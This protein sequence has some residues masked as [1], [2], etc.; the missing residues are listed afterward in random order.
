MTCLMLVTGSRTCVPS[1]IVCCEFFTKFAIIYLFSSGGR[2][3]QIQGSG[4]IACGQNAK[5]GASSFPCLRKPSCNGG[6]A[7][8]GHPRRPQNPPLPHITSSR[9]TR[10]TFSRARPSPFLNARKKLP[11]PHSF[12]LDFWAVRH[13]GPFS[14]YRSRRWT[15]TSASAD[16]SRTFPSKHSAMPCVICI[17]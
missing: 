15:S 8:P 11:T 1:L 13:R 6:T 10:S 5:P 16:D 9:L 12:T 4:A 3:K 17:M 2:G 14:R 7:N